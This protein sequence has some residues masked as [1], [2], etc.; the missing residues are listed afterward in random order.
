MPNIWPH[1]YPT[2]AIQEPDLESKGPEPVRSLLTFA[3]SKDLPSRLD[4]LQQA[5]EETL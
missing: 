1:P 4:Q 3:G 5:R 2:K